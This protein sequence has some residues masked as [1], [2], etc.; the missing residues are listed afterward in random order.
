MPA[1]DD[2]G[3]GDLFSGFGDFFADTTFQDVAPLIAPTIS[4]FGGGAAQPPAVQ[5]V[6]S[7]LPASFVP[8]SFDPSVG[9][10]NGRASPVMAEVPT[11]VRM[12]ATALRS[13]WNS[14]RVGGVHI[15]LQRVASLLRKY[16]PSFFFGW[17]A[18]EVLQRAFF[19]AVTKK[20]RRMNPANVRALR[21]SIRRVKSFHRLC[22]QADV[23]RSRGRSRAR[24]AVCGT[25]RKSPCRC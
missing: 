8:Y 13:L 2:W 15:S 1:Q 4:Y 23:L 24:S 25:C 19:D 16:G 20:S 9:Y 14:L 12:G 21:R 18:D 5:R 10:G 11:V 3:F 6:S 7:S 22:G 17:V